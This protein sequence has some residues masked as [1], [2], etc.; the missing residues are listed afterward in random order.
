MNTERFEEFSKAYR[1]CLLAAV[2]DPASG[3]YYGPEQVPA[4]AD[5]MLAAIASKPYGANYD[6]R[7]FKLT[8]K[9]LG[10]KN[11][12]KAILAFIGAQS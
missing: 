2:S 12:R 10:I 7:G 8:C 9:A 1:S 4:V 6:G 3:Y 11:T 5:K